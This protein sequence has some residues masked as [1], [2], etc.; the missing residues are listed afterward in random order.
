VKTGREGE[1]VVKTICYQCNSLLNM[2][3][4]DVHINM[5]VIS[6][7]LL[8]SHMGKYYSLVQNNGY[9]EKKVNHVFPHTIYLLNML[10][11]LNVPNPNPTQKI[12]FQKVPK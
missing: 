9:A 1:D 7:V 10:R 8:V 2:A 6:S 4:T 3:S 11:S 5:A 12:I